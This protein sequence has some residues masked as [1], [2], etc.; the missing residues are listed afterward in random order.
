MAAKGPSAEPSARERLSRAAIEVI[1]AEGFEAATIDQIVERADTDRDQ[2]DAHFAGKEDCYVQVLDG[3]MADFTGR[4]WMAFESETLWRDGMVE[5]GSAML[6]WIEGD[7]VRARFCGE[8][9]VAGDQ[10]RARRDL[11]VLGLAELID[12]GR[13]ELEDPE[14]VPRSTAEGIAGAIA[15][16]LIARLTAGELEALRAGWPEVLYS[17]LRPYIGGEAAR[18]VMERP[19]DPDA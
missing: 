3:L 14:S 19:P 16:M 18:E 15:D 17:A 7:P 6:S 2:F 12:Q 4:I 13:T 5:A 11:I 10:S 8:I 1:G 9:R